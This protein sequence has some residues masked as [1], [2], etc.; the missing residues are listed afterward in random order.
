M[1]QF[2]T[3]QLLIIAGWCEADENRLQLEAS[4]AEQEKNY[5]ETVFLMERLF[6]NREIGKTI[7]HQIA[8]G[9]TFDKAPIIEAE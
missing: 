5:G 1:V 9:S 8:A 6:K 2:T 7:S 4:T 3:T